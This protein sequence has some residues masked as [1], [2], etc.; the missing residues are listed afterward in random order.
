MNW[1]ERAEKA[2]ADLRALQ[3]R[4]ERLV[5]ALRLGIGPPGVYVSSEQEHEEW[6]NSIYALLADEPK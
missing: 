6:L 1:E 5:K 3:A 4:H 2:E